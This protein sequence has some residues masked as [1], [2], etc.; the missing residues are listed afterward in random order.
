HLPRLSGAAGPRRGRAA[1]RAV[2]EGHLRRLRGGRDRLLPYLPPALPR[3]R[4]GR[5]LPTPL[6]RPARPPARPLR[7]PPA[8]PA[9]RPPRPERAAG[10]PAARGLLRP[11]RLP[12]PAH[13]RA[14]GSGQWLV[15]SGQ[16]RRRCDPLLVTN[17][18]PLLTPAPRPVRSARSGTGGRARR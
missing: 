7:L 11:A 13:P 12:A 9:A 2:A 6:P 15:V 17:H 8:H 16:G 5:P 1:G 3:P 14:V 4:P 10:L 18:G